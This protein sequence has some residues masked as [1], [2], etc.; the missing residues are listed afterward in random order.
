MLSTPPR[1]VSI[2]DKERVLRLLLRSGAHITEVNTVRRH[3]SLVKGGQ[4]AEVA[5]PARGWVLL[6]SDVPGDDPVDVASGPFSPD[7]TTY[8]DALHVL[9]RRRILPEVPSSVREHLEAGAVGEVPRPSSRE[10]QPSGK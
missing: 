1:G 5:R 3:L 6:L 2:G 9:A 4:M 7:P 10:H 8:R